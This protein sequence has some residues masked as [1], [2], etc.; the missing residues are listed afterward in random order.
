MKEAQ[1][2]LAA[3][4]G[5]AVWHWIDL[6]PQ[7]FSDAISGPRRMDGAPER[8]YDALSQ[9]NDPAHKQIT[10]PTLSILMAVSYERLERVLSQYHGGRQSSRK[11]SAPLY[12]NSIS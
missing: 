4:I 2:I 7:E 9:L 11:V 12:S 3:P 1:L 5:E 8:L 6:Y 10:L